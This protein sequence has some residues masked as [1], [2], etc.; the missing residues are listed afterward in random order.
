MIKAKVRICYGM[1]LSRKVKHRKTYTSP[2][3]FRNYEVSEPEVGKVTEN[4][5]L[6]VKIFELGRG[7]HHVNG[8]ILFH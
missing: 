3:N 7:S 4:E 6:S 5:I 8:G 1:V 2:I